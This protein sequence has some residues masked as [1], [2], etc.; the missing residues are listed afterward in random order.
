[1]ICHSIRPRHVFGIALIHHERTGNAFVCL[2]A[3][4]TAA[5]HLGNLLVRVCHCQPFRHDR[6]HARRR[7]AECIRQQRERVF[8]ANHDG[9]VIRR[10][11]LV[12]GGHQR[13]AE[14]VARAPA[15]NTRRA[16]TRHYLAA[17]VERQVG[18]QRDAPGLATILADGTL[19]H[20]RLGLELAVQ[21][22]QRIEHQEPV[23]A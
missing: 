8:Q 6:A 19:G 20:L 4:R 11:D 22:E 14:A 2:V 3:V 21:P 12:G 7:L 16:I 1:M 15:A 9:L 10:A 18:T 17:V 5:D 23:I 13:L